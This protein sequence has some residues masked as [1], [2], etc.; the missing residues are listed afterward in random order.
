MA[1][2]R[3]PA[4]HVFVYRTPRKAGTYV[5]LPGRDAFDAL[6]PRLRESLGSLALVME[7]DLWHGRRLARGSADEVMAAI[8]ARGYH[9]QLPPSDPSGAPD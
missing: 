2:A 8:A 4:M 9:L 1:D 6:P 5:F 3:N 7:L